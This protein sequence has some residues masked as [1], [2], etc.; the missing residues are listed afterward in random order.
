MRLL[1]RIVFGLAAAYTLFALASSSMSSFITVCAVLAL[2]VAGWLMRRR[3]QLLLA[4]V[5]TTVTAAVTGYFAAAAEFALGASSPVLSGQ[6]VFGY[7]ALAAMALLGAWMPKDH[8]GRRG[9]T[10]VAADV[11][12]VVTSGVGTA[13]PTVSVPLGFLGLT[14]VLVA[15]GGGISALRRR[16]GRV[17]RLF[18]RRAVPAADTDR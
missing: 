12:L 16:S 11:V 15:R 4:L 5:S 17:K 9:I 7:W 2:A 3:G 10:V 13:F 18:A 1:R 14:L 8:P 6:A